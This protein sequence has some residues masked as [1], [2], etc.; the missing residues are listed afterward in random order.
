MALRV[1]IVDGRK[2]G[3]NFGIDRR[4]GS[5]EDRLI[6]HGWGVGVE[7][8]KGECRRGRVGGREERV[9][10]APF[11]PWQNNKDTSNS[12]QS[13]HI[14]IYIRQNFQISAM[15]CAKVRAVWKALD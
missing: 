5:R 3:W 4:I 7:T 14:S 12:S 1:V 9:R 11:F 8:G 15:N 10:E 2:Q 13:M 6:E